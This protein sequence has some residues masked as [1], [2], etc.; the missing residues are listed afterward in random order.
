MNFLHHLKGAL[1]PIPALEDAASGLGFVNWLP[2]DD[3]VI[4]RVPL[5][6]N[7]NGQIEPSLAVETLR[8]AQGARSYV[9]KSATVF[10]N[11]AGK[12]A[13]VEAIKVGNVVVPVQADGEL[14]V[15]FAKSDPRRSIPAWKVLQPNPDLSDLAGK[16]VFVGTSASLLSDIVAT[17]LNPS[18]P[19]VEVH[20][21]LLEQI[22][23]GLT[24][25][26]PDWAR[27]AELVVSAVLSLAF[28]A[29]L[30]FVAVYWTALFG[31][32]ATTSFAYLSWFA[33][34]RHG[35]LIDPA[36]YARP[37]I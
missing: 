22:L 28:A 10:G 18:T 34:T 35:I 31:F 30:P 3:R 16:I 2:D 21:Q 5:M 32:A 20:A 23:S 24:L 26:R 15:W 1:V 19:G 29:I 14:R 17:P 4:R 6:L 7:L 11:T 9:V 25:Q 36:G 13:G 12:S 8:V 33:F 27:G 37:P